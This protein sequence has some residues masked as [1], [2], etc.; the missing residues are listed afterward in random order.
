MI[1]V[2]KKTNLPELK[3]KAWNYPVH[4]RSSQP[5]PVET[6]ETSSWLQNRFRGR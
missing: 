3:Y 5:L 1:C 4:E 2:D 6:T